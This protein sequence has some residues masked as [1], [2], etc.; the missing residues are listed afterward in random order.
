MRRNYRDRRIERPA[1][2]IPPAMLLAAPHHPGLVNL[3]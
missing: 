3:T 1:Y 2:A